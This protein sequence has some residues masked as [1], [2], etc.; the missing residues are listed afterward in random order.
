MRIFKIALKALLVVAFLAACNV[1]LTLVLEPYG[2]RSQLAWS[3]YERQDEL[4]TIVVGTSH[5]E[6]GVDPAVLNKKCGCKAYNLGTPNQSVEESFLAIRTAWEDHQIKRVVFGLSPSALTSS[7]PPNPG[8]AFMR[9]RNLYVTPFEAAASI[10]EFMWK[11]GAATTAYSLDF[12]FPWASNP[13]RSLNPK[14]LVAN[15]KARIEGADVAEMAQ[16]LEHGWRYVGLGHGSRG[17]V[18]NLDGSGV[19]SITEGVDEEAEVDAADAGDSATLNPD[20]AAVLREIASYC[21]ERG[22]ELVVV[23]PPL[24]VYDVFDEKSTYFETMDE[25][26]ALFGELG[27]EVYDFNLASSDLFDSEPE[28]F[29]DNYHL[30][31]QGAQVF[32]RSLARFL[33]ALDDGDDVSGMFVTPEERLYSIDYLSAL[34]AE[35]RTDAEGVHLDWRLVTSPTED[36]EYRVMMRHGEDEEFQPVSEWSRETSFTYLPEERG[37]LSLRICARHV[38]SDEE[39]E[40]FRTERVLW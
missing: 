11:Y 37:A 1:A 14:A 7:T 12:V 40:R 21:A 16:K 35:T 9:N 34:F 31:L 30:N 6:Y 32:S 36:V 18:M 29:A 15:V 10:H 39:Y 25:A 20:R 19:R 3:D 4:D 5:M 17:K 23:A 28:L 27:L 24:P 2:S 22:I 33:N 26:R 38:G 8:S 13:I